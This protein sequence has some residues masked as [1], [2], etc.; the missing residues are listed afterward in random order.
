MAVHNPTPICD[1]AVFNIL[2]A[3]EPYASLA[4]FTD[5]TDSWVVHMGTTNDPTKEAIFDPLLIYKKP[6]IAN[7]RISNHKGEQFVIVH[8]YDRNPEFKVLIENTYR[9]E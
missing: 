6:Q 5:L 4:Y 7:G 1:Q 3:T 2:M 8:Q 9:D